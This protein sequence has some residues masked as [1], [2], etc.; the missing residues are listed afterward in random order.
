MTDMI[1]V[2]TVMQQETKWLPKC[3]E[4]FGIF[5]WSRVFCAAKGPRLT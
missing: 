2:R 5:L 1:D 3:T 4:H